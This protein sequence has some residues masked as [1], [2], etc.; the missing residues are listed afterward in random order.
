MCVYGR[1]A[2]SSIGTVYILKAIKLYLGLTI[3]LTYYE[4]FVYISNLIHT[5]YLKNILVFVEI[6]L[7]G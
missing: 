3:F 2:N 1:K 5:V 4:H 7:V 6:W